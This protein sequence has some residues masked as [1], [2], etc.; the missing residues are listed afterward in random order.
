MV[1]RSSPAAVVEIAMATPRIRKCP[2]PWVR[3]PLWDGFW[4]LSAIWLAPIVLW[5]TIGTP[6]FCCRRDGDCNPQGTSRDGKHKITPFDHDLRHLTSE[7]WTVR[8][9]A[10]AKTGRGENERYFGDG[11]ACPGGVPPVGNNRVTTK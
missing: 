8:T 7:A 3:G 6:T 9:R 10:N 5:L 2:S 11:A 1:E 4:M